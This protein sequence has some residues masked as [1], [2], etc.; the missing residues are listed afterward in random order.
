VIVDEGG[1]LGTGALHEL[2]TLVDQHHWRLALVGDPN[3]LQAVGRGG[4]FHE[5]CA[6]GRTY[7]LA[8]IRRFHQPWEAAASLQLRHGDPTALDVYEA[9][10]RIIPGTLDDHLERIT[11]TWMAVAAGDTI[12]VTTA[13]NDHLDAINLA[14]QAASSAETWGTTTCSPG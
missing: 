7:E 9:H 6:T 11:E 12:A 10:D 8:R 3:Q 2:V 4:L 13:S 5:L 1:M 14:I